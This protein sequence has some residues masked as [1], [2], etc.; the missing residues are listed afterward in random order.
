M[1]PMAISTV[2]GPRG[3]TQCPVTPHSCYSARGMWRAFTTSALINVL[4]APVST[5]SFHPLC[6][7]LGLR[8]ERTGGIL[9]AGGPDRELGLSDGPRAQPGPVSQLPEILR[10]LAAASG[11]APLAAV[12]T[13]G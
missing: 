4:S 1:S 12:D 10:Q 3:V 5:T 6:P 7:G 8:E 13:A 9:I 11:V 2:T